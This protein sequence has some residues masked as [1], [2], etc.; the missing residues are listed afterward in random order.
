[1]RRSDAI[2]HLASTMGI[3]STELKSYTRVLREAGEFS[4]S[5]PGRAANPITEDDLVSLLIGYCASRTAVGAANALRTVRGFKFMDLS[6]YDPENRELPPFAGEKSFDTAFRRA[7]WDAYGGNTAKWLR[8]DEVG[9]VGHFC[10]DF[11]TS[12]RVVRIKASRWRPGNNGRD[13]FV[14]QFE[15]RYA[16]DEGFLKGDCLESR[17]IGHLT[18]HRVGELLID[19][20]NA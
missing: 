10:V 4:G 18:L 8:H 1:M 2:A 9:I 12:A 6:L 20:A 14:A 16:A 7:I 11:D 19:G 3:S 15:L 13:K 5:S 17:A